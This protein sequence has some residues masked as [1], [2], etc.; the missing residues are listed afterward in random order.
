MS[1]QLHAPPTLPPRPKWIE[2]WVDPRAGLDAVAR[3]K[4]SQPVPAINL[5]HMFIHQRNKNL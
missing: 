2:G 4:K 3:I 5:L 1:G